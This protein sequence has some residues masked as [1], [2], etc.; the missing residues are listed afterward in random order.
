MVTWWCDST[1]QAIITPLIPLRS[2]E[3]ELLS[4]L[5]EGNVYR[6][7]D[8]VI[9]ERIGERGPKKC[10]RREYQVGVLANQLHSCHL[11]KTCG[12]VETSR[13]SLLIVKF[14]R[15]P[16]LIKYLDKCKDSDVIAHQMCHLVLVIYHL[17]GQSDFCHYGLHGSNVIMK[18][19]SKPKKFSYT[20]F[21]Q[22]Y[23]ITNTYQPV[24]IDLGRSYINGLGE[25]YYEEEQVNVQV[26][27]GIFDSQLDL[28]WL[29]TGLRPWL[30]K[31]HRSAFKPLAIN[32]LVDHRN[33]RIIRYVSLHKSL[34]FD[35]SFWASA[36]P[37]KGSISQ[38]LDKYEYE[39]HR[40]RMSREEIDASSRRIAGIILNRKLSEVRKRSL[41][42][43]EVFLMILKSFT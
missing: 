25:G 35:Q 36:S 9:K 1:A 12:Y 21:G 27:P 34:R 13:S 32:G 15:G 37:I 28:A 16:T 42:D 5:R 26:S 29:F 22:S 3:L 17:Q 18:K 24:I 14:V 2:R 11:V 7:G 38:A 43:K 39:Y 8:Y 31:K 33:H 23:S 4:K 20:I 30:V 10:I 41:S 6:Y 19:L 40:S